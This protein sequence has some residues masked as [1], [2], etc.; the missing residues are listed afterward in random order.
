LWVSHRLEDWKGGDVE[1]GVLCVWLLPRSR[2]RRGV[3]VGEKGVF[4]SL[5][6]LGCRGLPR[7]GEGRVALF[8]G[9][10]SCGCPIGATG[11]PIFTIWE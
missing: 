10:F 1:V 2:E 11:V 9:T 3:H 5:G 7:Q 4:F 8:P 6:N